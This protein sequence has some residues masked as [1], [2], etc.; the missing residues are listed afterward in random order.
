MTLRKH[1]DGWIAQNW[2]D[3]IIAIDR[4]KIPVFLYP[5]L[6]IHGDDICIEKPKQ[7]RKK[8]NKAL[9]RS[10]VHEVLIRKTALKVRAA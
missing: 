3:G 9:Q 5:N 10:P 4:L 2:Y 6:T 8:L 7:L 1:P